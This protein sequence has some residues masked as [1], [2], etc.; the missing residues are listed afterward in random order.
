M[1]GKIIFLFLVLLSSSASVVRSS[2]QSKTYVDASKPLAQIID[3]NRRAEAWAMC[4]ATYELMS[5]ILSKAQPSRSLQLSELANGAKVAVIMTVF[6]DGFDDNIAPERFNA[7]WKTAILA[8]AT[9]PKTRR[10]FLDAEAEIATGNKT[11]KFI[12]T[13]SATTE[14]CIKNLPDQQMYIDAKNELMKSG[15]FKFPNE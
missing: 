3:V 4:A 5:E 7:L 12:T 10:T 2:V 9:L 14:V 8:G 13:L 11:S 1:R 15:L 6:I